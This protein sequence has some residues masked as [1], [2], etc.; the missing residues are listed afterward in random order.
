MKKLIVAILCMFVLTSCGVSDDSC[1]LNSPAVRYISK[2]VEYG[3]IIDEN[4][5]NI[6]LK[7][8]CGR[9]AGMS[10]VMNSDGTPMTLEQL[11]EKLEQ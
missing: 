4:T 11:K 6:Y 7:F 3:Y 2:N 9:Q 10:I 8:S 1:E 5:N